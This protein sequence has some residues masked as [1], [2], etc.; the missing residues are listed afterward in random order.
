M[1]GLIFCHCLRGKLTISDDFSNDDSESRNALASDTG[2][3]E[4]KSDADDECQ[5]GD[6][7]IVPA[8][9]L[10]SELGIDG[11]EEIADH[12]VAVNAMAAMQNPPTYIVKES[13]G[14]VRADTTVA[15]LNGVALV[16]VQNTG[17]SNIGDVD[18]TAVPVEHLIDNN[19][20][21]G[22]PLA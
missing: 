21:R 14:A 5:E 22:L 3:A 2:H 10:T 6:R 4:D 18:V 20:S 1:V 9:G 13:V 8:V 12:D 16:A 7:R 15:E 11:I 19:V 17:E